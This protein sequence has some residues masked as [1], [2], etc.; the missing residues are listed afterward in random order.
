MALES[1]LDHRPRESRLRPSG[2]S[3]RLMAVPLQLVHGGPVFGSR[4]AYSDRFGLGPSA[5]LTPARLVLC[6]GALRRP[7]SG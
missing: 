1:I 2:G 7:R 5:P 4:C 3:H 6:V